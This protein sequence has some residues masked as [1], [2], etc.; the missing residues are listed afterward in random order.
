[1]EK[2]PRIQE[3]PIIL[4]PAAADAVNAAQNALETTAENLLKS[5]VDRVAAA[6]V[7]RPDEDPTTVAQDI[8]QE[9]QDALADLQT[10]LDTARAA[11]EEAAIRYTFRPL[12]FKVWRA[13]KANHPSKDKDLAFDYDSIVPDL[14][15]HASYEPKLSA[16]DVE[17]IL[18]SPDWAESEVNL[19]VTAALLAQA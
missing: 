10:T 7:L 3:A 9:D 4:D 2:K 14:L 19:L 1:M 11:L 5:F 17:D 12:G 18:E 15:K 16:G 6:Q 8:Y 13:M